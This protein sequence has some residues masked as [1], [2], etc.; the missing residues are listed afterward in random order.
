[1]PA[2]LWT[3]DEMKIFELALAS[4][5]HDMEGR[6]ER[7]Q[8]SLPNKTIADIKKA[9]EQLEVDLRAI[10]TSK[11]PSDNDSY[12]ATSSGS[13]SKKKA[14]TAANSDDQG[15]KGVAWSEEEH[16]LF[17]AGLAKFGKGSWRSI[18]RQF[19]MTRTPTQVA[20]HAQK[21]FLRLGGNKK[22]KR[23]ASIHDITTNQGHHHAAALDWRVNDFGSL[24]TMFSV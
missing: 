20:S 5:L 18:S 8:L 12:G 16:R 23:R 3:F 13:G 2:S 6:W 14:K 10:H 1:M 21:Y 11:D 24:H 9:Y 17:L 7:I 19:V 4:H 15:K 22:E